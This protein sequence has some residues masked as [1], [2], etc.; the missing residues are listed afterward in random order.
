MADPYFSP[1]TFKF[2][3][4]LSSHND[5]TWFAANK[6]RYERD[7]RD[8]FLALLSALDAPVAK[9]SGR[10]RVDARP[11][12]GSLFRIH[13][14]ARFSHDKSPYKTWA[15]ARV[16]HEQRRE[17]QCPVFYIH[18]QP[19]HCF[20]AAGVWHPEP[21]ALKRI[22]AFLLDNPKA[23]IAATRSPAFLKRYALGGESLTRPPRGIDP[24]HPLAD[25]LKRKD[26]VASC[27]F[28]E[29]DFCARSAPREIAKAIAGLAPL[30]D[31]LCS[32]LDLEF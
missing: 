6:A 23:W 3:R 27:D 15:G 17:C 25:D 24:T 19:G 8:P 5:R 20:V 10:Y 12:G 21:D 32:A 22:R 7:V 9:V 1:A 14:D 16:F 26:F 28:T 4:E 18:V 29:A 30:V 13:R 2:L 31:Y 11:S